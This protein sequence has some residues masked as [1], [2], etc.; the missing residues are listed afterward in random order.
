MNSPIWRFSKG[1]SSFAIVKSGFDC[2]FYLHKL[3]YLYHSWCSQ[4]KIK[5]LEFTD[6]VE[7]SQIILQSINP[8]INCRKICITNFD[9]WLQAKKNVNWS[10]K[11]NRK[12]WQRIKNVW[13][14]W[15]RCKKK[16]KISNRSWGGEKLQNLLQRS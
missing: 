12:I 3:K 6:L 4:Y 9:K 8:S 7:V 10:Q 15:K 14:P 5:F 11:K 13:I 16:C 2:T 1:S